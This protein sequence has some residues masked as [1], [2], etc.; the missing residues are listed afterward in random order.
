MSDLLN[1][2]AGILTGLSKTPRKKKKKRPEFS[3]VRELI[4]KSHLSAF[5]NLFGASDLDRLPRIPKFTT[6]L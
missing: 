4:Y 5:S 1:A 6:Y 2:A 3:S